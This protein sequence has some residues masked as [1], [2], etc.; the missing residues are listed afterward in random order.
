MK[1]VPGLMTVMFYFN[2]LAYQIPLKI[3]TVLA[4]ER[5]IEQTTLRILISMTSVTISMHVSGVKIHPSIMH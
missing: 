4:T 1:Q 3:H 2:K 5:E